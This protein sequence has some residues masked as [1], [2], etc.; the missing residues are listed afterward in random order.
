MKLKRP[1]SEIVGIALFLVGVAVLDQS[2]GFAGRAVVRTP[3]WPD[4]GFTKIDSTPQGTFVFTGDCRPQTLRADDVGKF[5]GI[6]VVNLGVSAL[7]LGQILFTADYLS[8]ISGPVKNGTPR[9]HPIIFLTDEILVSAEADLLRDLAVLSFY[10]ALLPDGMNA[11][12]FKDVGL[13]SLPWEK[14]SGLYHFRGRGPTLAR[15]AY[16]AIRGAPVVERSYEDNNFPFNG[17]QLAAQDEPVPPKEDNWQPAA[18]AMKILAN[19]IQ[20]LKAASI[21]PTLVLPPMHRLR[22]HDNDRKRVVAA[23]AQLA[24]E[25]SVQLLNY[26]DDPR[27]ADDIRLWGNPGHMNYAGNKYFSEVLAQDLKTKIP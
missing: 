16:A 26:L 3:H 9:F 5:L 8:S 23:G 19:R 27:F 2:V 11:P 4:Q 12:L 15:T 25:G 21:P 22:Q 18:F 7:G 14:Y 24:R 6:P 10:A 20:D 17:R 1:Y 13:G